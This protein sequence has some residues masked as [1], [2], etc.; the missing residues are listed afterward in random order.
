[1]P[2]DIQNQLMENFA[3]MGGADVIAFPSPGFDEAEDILYKSPVSTATKAYA[4]IQKLMRK[5]D[6]EKAIAELNDLIKT[7]PRGP[8]IAYC[9]LALCYSKT[10]Q[11]DN[12][13]DAYTKAAGATNDKLV[14]EAILHRTNHILFS[15]LFRY[16]EAEKGIRTYLDR[17]PH[18]TWRERERG[19]LARV[20]R[21]RKKQ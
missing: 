2:E 15:K 4:N 12:A 17:Y 19:L 8:D 20:E 7:R 10:D 18:G 13:I 11:W 21:A 1:M 5:G 3:A 6:Y 9:D 14:R 16:D